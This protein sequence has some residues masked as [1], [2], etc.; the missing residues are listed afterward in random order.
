MSFRYV[1]LQ[2]ILR[3][4]TKSPTS[5]I[6]TILHALFL[7]TPFKI[8]ANDTPT[9]KASGEVGVVDKSVTALPEEILK[10]GALYSN[11]GVLNLMIPS[12]L[13]TEEEGSE[14]EKPTGKRKDRAEQGELELPDDGELGGEKLGRRIWEYFEDELKKW[15]TE[16]PRT[17]TEHPSTSGT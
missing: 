8:L 9:E 7:P 3:I 15:D 16:H 4:L 12:S 6:Q 11:C 1:L 14:D 5:S 17:D 13:Q 10:P 2:P